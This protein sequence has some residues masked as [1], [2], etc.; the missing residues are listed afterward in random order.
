MVW[1][2]NA[3]RFSEVRRRSVA[4]YY[5]LNL[6]IADELFVLTLPFLCVAT[7]TGDWMF[8]DAA[9]RLTYT[10]R[11]TYKYA[12]LLTLLALSVDRCLATY[13]RLAHLRSIAVGIGVCVVVWV[14]SLWSAW[15]VSLV[16]AGT[17]YA[18]YSRVL[19]RAGSRSC[20][21]RWPWTGQIV[22]QRVWTYGHLVVPG[23]PW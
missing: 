18:V 8:G 10:L 6:A 13:H 12:S 22:V 23:G 1:C 9:C 21:V 3:A 7:Y 20:L 16:G 4:N 2:N 11:E 15:V 14:V 17:P 5:I 19:E